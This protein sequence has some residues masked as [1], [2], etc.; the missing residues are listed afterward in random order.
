MQQIKN[1]EYEGERPLFAMHGENIRIENYSQNG[2]YSCQL[3][4]PVVGRKKL[5]L[6]MRNNFDER[7]PRQVLIE[8]LD[9]LRR[10][11]T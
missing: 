3:R 1:K 9:R 8:G 6:R 11:L 5:L 2:N 10:V 7:I 4:T